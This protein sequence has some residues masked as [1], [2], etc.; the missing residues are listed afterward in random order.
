MLIKLALNRLRLH[1][2]KKRANI[3][4]Q[5][6]EIGALLRDGKE[7]QARIRVHTLSFSF[8]STNDAELCVVR[9]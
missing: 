6:R 5:K 7:E 3:E 2:A 8:S 9:S 4:N 1:K